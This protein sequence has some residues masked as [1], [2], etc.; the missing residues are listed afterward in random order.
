MSGPDIFVTL[1]TFSNE[2]DEPLRLL[3]AGGLTF[4]VNALGRRLTPA[5][6]IE[7]GGDSRGLVAGVEP[8]DAGT[9]AFL[10]RLRC[11]SRCGAG[12]DSIDLKAA[13]ARGIAVLNTPDEPTIAVAEHTLAMM[14]ALLKQLPKVDSLTRERKWQRVTGSLL[15]G[16]VVGIIGLGRIG[17]RVAE[18]VQAFGASVIAV[19]PYPEPDWVEARAVEVVAL[20]A[21]LARA[22]ILTIHAATKPGPAFHLG[23]DEIDRMKPGAWLLNMARGDMVDEPALCEALKSGRLSGAA[24]DVFANE[25]YH[26]PLCDSEKVILTPHQATLTRE[27]RGAMETRAVENLL[28]CLKGEV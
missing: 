4:S 3:K 8:Y 24:L 27:T 7:M 26:G 16:K 22:D 14:L 5:E 23:P 11:I 1:S 9:L 18:L 21:L 19:E 17:R 13:E 28:R 6:V 20:P 15:H 10:P 2:S 25:P 12:I